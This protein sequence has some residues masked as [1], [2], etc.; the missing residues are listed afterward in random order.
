MDS[1]EEQVKQVTS[2]LAVIQAQAIVVAFLASLFAITL[3]W[4]P[5]GKVC[6]VSVIPK[7]AA[8]FTVAFS[9]KNILFFKYFDQKTIPVYV[10]RGTK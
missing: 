3:A 1:R 8:H 5:K 7:T 10:V 9:P 2:N 6:F 4:V